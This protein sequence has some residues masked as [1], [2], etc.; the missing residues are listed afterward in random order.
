MMRAGHFVAPETY[1]HEQPSPCKRNCC[2]TP[3]GHSTAATTCTCH[4]GV[5]MASRTPAI[6]LLAIERRDG[7]RRCVMTGT[8][9]DRIVPQHRQGGMGGRADKH[10]PC[11]VVWLDSLVNGH[12]EAD[13]EW[14]AIA[15]AWGV[16]V[17][18]WV[19]D[20]TAV[21]VYFRF[22]H[23]WFLLEGESRRLITPIDALDR[24]LAVYGDDYLLWKG[25]ADDTDR[26]RALFLR[27]GH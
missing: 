8:E 27:G 15:K 17:P 14:Q 6:T 26:S 13:A 10:R 22:E 4:Q 21:P 19:A 20:V 23:A 24:M 18:I 11:N 7:V 12:V 9:G 2:W 3:H 5:P 25:I 16:K 1:P